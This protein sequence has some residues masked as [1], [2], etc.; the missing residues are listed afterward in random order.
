MDNGYG[1]CT[2]VFFCMNT[3]S[4]FWPKAFLFGTVN[5]DNFAKW[6]AART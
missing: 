2:C 6:D 5:T 3:L 1:K 4:A